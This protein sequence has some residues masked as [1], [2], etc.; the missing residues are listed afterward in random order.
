MMSPAGTVVVAR[1][2]EAV[3]VRAQAAKA[4]W[5]VLKA[6]ATMETLLAFIERVRRLIRLLSGR[7]EQRA[8]S[9]RGEA[10]EEA[11]EG[12]YR[13]RDQVEVRQEITIILRRMT[14]DEG[15][16]TTL[17]VRMEKLE[18]GYGQGAMTETLFEYEA[19]LAA[20][21]SR[22]RRI[23]AGSLAG[24]MPSTGDGVRP[25]PV[26]DPSEPLACTL[27]AFASLCER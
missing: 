25:L 7:E 18:A 23:G 26:P 21:E 15:R 24:N 5:E 11:L 19:T 3:V 22:A 14:D 1:R 17:S 12:L 4:V 13:L 20:F 2:A 9:E 8:R 16:L 6:L 10:E 27:R